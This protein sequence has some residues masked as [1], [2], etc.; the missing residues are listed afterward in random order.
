MLYTLKLDFAEI[1]QYPVANRPTVRSTSIAHLLTEL[2][3]NP[4][5]KSKVQRPGID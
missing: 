1:V 2:V 3:F 4:S 5:Q